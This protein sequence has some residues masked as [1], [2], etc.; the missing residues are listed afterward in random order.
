M[1]TLHSTKQGCAGLGVLLAG[2]AGVWRK[3]GRSHPCQLCA[4]LLR[5]AAGHWR[6][7]VSSLEDAR[8]LDVVFLDPEL[9]ARPEN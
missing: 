5:G 6:L 1:P 7:K 8:P 4:L 9:T 2:W 3:A